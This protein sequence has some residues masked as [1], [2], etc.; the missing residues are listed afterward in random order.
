MPLSI[1]LIV[2]G[3]LLIALTYGVLNAIGVVLTA[4]GVGLLLSALVGAYNG[5]R[6]TL[7]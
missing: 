3:V 4:V 7:P 5:R 2:V 1:L 6:G